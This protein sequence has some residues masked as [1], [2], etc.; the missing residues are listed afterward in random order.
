[1]EPN[2]FYHNLECINCQQKTTDNPYIT[3]ETY[4]SPH[5]KLLHSDYYWTC[6]KCRQYNSGNVDL[7]CKVCDDEKLTEQRLTSEKHDIVA[8]GYCDEDYPCYHHCTVRFEDGVEHHTVMCASTIYDHKT[9][10]EADLL[11]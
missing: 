5:R 1:M 4:C 9:K 10:N 3:R 2:K 6:R 8:V 7:I 11:S